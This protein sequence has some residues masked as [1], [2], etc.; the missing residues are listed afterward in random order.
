MIEF[1]FG[2]RAVGVG[3]FYHVGK[4]RLYL[5]PFPGVGVALHFRRDDPGVVCKAE[6]GLSDEAV[7]R[8][9]AC[10]TRDGAR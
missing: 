4:R 10:R 9:V 6:E 5:H 7:R 3:I 8:L 1:L 2:R